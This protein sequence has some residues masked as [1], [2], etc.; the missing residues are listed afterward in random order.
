MLDIAATSALEAQTLHDIRELIDEVAADEGHSPL[1]EHKQ[2][3]LTEGVGDWLGVLA[4]EPDSRRLRAY[5]HARWGPPGAT[6]R[7]AVE[8]VAASDHRDDALAARLLE[9]VRSALRRAGGGVLHLWVHG[10]RDSADTVGA[11]LGLAVQRELAFM[12]RPL[13][14]PPTATLPEGVVLAAHRPGADD[15]ELLRVNNAAFAGHP[16][17][18]D[19]SQRD[20]DLRRSLPWFDPADLLSAWR[21]AQLLGFHWTKRH[22]PDAGEV[23]GDTPTGEVY[24]LA[25]DPGA[26][27]AGLGRGL[28]RAGL[29]HLHERGCRR[30]VLYVDRASRPAVALYESEGF[31]T[32]SLEVCY[33][34]TVG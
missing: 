23:A 26:H 17:N 8:L 11:R 19:W 3:Q 30:G 24:V 29:A 1:G 18:G 14:H 7:V 22:M 16:E 21:G 5:A 31:A 34:E 13:E 32:V 6:P 15:A 20:L 12:H 2:V 10:A 33:E 4:R 28:L 27:G 25:V 9:E